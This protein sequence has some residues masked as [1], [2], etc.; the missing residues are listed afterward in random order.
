MIW[1]LI[2]KEIQEVLCSYEH[3][4]V[5]NKYI[6]LGLDIYKNDMEFD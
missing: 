5:Y 6:C 1:N 3:E 4:K 2:N